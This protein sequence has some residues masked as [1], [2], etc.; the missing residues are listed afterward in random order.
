VALPGHREHGAPAGGERLGAALAARP[1]L[2][3]LVV[4]LTAGDVDA[5]GAAP[6]AIAHADD[7]HAAGADL[8]RLVAVLEADQPRGG[9]LGQRLRRAVAGGDATFAAQGR[10]RGLGDRARDG[11][12]IDLLDDG[13]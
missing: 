11:A 8:E 9:E 7:Q 12:A 3:R 4:E 6:H 5:L 10:R 13:L 2:R 1:T